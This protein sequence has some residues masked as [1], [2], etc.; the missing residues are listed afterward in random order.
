M[1]ICHVEP[2][3]P[4]RE[5]HGKLTHSADEKWYRYLRRGSPPPPLARK[6]SRRAAA[7][8]VSLGALRAPPTPSQN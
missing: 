8:A 7:N 4:S 6:R 1:V 5:C 3:E 2:W